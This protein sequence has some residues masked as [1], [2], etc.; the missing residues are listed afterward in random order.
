MIAKIGKETVL[1]DKISIAISPSAEHHKGIFNLFVFEGPEIVEH[2]Q[3]DA[4]YLEDWV[5]TN[6][7]QTIK[8]EA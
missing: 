6:L 3:A 4:A 1:V 2:V 7:G 5:K 8:I